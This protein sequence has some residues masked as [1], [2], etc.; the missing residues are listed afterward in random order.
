MVLLLI[1][2]GDA[3]VAIGVAATGGLLVVRTTSLIVML[4]VLVG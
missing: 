3:F 1:L 4:T 2:A